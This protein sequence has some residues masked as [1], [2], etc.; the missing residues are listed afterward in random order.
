MENDPAVTRVVNEQRS[1]VCTM[2]YSFV[3]G[4]V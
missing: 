3:C 4:L 1:I 2:S